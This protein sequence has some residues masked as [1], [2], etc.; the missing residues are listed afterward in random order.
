MEPCHRQHSCGAAVGWLWGSCGQCR[1]CTCL[2][3]EMQVW[4]AWPHRRD[5][6]AVPVS[7]GTQAS[8]QPE[9]QHL[10]LPGQSRSSAQRLGQ[11]A[12]LLRACFHGQKPGLAGGEGRLGLGVELAWHHGTCISPTEQWQGGTASPAWGHPGHLTWLGTHAAGTA[13]TGAALLPGAACRVVAAA[14]PAAL[15]T[16][17]DSTGAVARVLCRGRCFSAATCPGSRART[18]VARYGYRPPPASHPPPCPRAGISRGEPVVPVV[19]RRQVLTCPLWQHFSAP[20][21][22]WSEMQY[23]LGGRRDLLPTAGHSPAL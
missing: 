17:A 9:K 5:G 1:G 15:P 10:R 19:G 8:P 2:G 11:A 14:H 6:G 12:A 4:R 7:G 18:R 16:G 13:A 22:L 23:S 21:Q 3:R 20:G